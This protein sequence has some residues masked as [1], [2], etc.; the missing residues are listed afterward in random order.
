MGQEIKLIA[1]RRQGG[2]ITESVLH[3]FLTRRL[4]AFMV[5]RFIEFLTDL[6]YTDVGKLKRDDL[7][8][9]TGREWDARA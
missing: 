7:A 5:P 1:V 3:D 6:P 4:A 2:E 8:V 9:L